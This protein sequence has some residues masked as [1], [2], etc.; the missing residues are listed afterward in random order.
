VAQSLFAGGGDS[1]EESPRLFLVGDAYVEDVD[2]AS[3]W[4]TSS[5]ESIST[6][7]RN[8]DHKYYFMI[9]ENMLEIKIV[10]AQQQ[11]TIKEV[12][13]E[14]QWCLS[15]RSMVDAPAVCKSFVVLNLGTGTG[16][17]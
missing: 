2:S 17:A 4:L 9:L 16:R 8:H 13:F 14:I 12:E 15:T 10:I 11:K 5:S 6:L 7:Y 3:N 1:G